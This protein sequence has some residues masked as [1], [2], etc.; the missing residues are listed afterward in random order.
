[1]AVDHDLL[2]ELRMAR[3]GVT[4]HMRVGGRL[5]VKV[6]Y[7]GGVAR[8]VCHV[9]MAAMANAVVGCRVN[10]GGGVMMAMVMVRPG[11]G[12]SRQ[13]DR[14]HGERDRE[15]K[16]EGHGL[17][18]GETGTVRRLAPATVSTPLARVPAS[19]R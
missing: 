17:S 8:R 1:M 9:V 13:S 10:G 11:H 4:R 15:R 19:P 6:A 18:L 5:G 3:G 16:F 14:R 7:S 2:A 12:R